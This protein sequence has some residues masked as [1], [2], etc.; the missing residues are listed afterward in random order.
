[1]IKKQHEPGDIVANRYEIVSYIN[2]GGMQEVFLA[3]DINLKRNVALKTPKN[4][5]AAKRFARSAILSARIHHPNVAKTLDFFEFNQKEYLI[6]EYIPGKDLK[7]TFLNTIVN[8]DPYLVARIFHHLSKGLSA[9]HHVGVIH[10]DLKPSNVMIAG[11]VSIDE[12]KITDFGI[13]KMVQGEI[14]EAVKGG[15]ETI[16]GNTTM[17]GALPYMSPEMIEDPHTVD[18]ASDIWSLGAIIFELLSGEKPFGTGYKAVKRIMLDPPPGK[19]AHIANNAQFEE[20]G[21]ELYDIILLCLNKNPSER[22]TSDALVN[23]CGG[24]CY[25]VARREI[26]RVT[27]IKYNSWGFISCASGGD[28]AFF[29]LENVYG[30]KP[31]VGDHVCFSKYPGEP[32]PRAFPVVVMKS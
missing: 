14:E 2:E 27:T 17:A 19:P 25:Q 8:I 15:E 29:H 28:D 32:Y 6:E 1:V 10:R 12:I 13:S 21:D 20:L 23:I 3:N 9:S 24:M 26:G 7:K 16:T 30:V 31:S 18:K 11:G 22:P 4:P 5:S